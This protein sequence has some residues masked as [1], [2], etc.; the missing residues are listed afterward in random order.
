MNA[1]HLSDNIIRLRHERKLTQE[2]LADFIGV[3]KA[4]VSKWEH[5]QSMPDLLLLPQLASFFGVSI[6]EL[7]GYEAQLS[8]EQIRRYYAE[9]SKDFVQ[10]PFHEVVEKIR[11]LAH[12]YYSCYP[13]LIQLCVLYWNHFMLAETEEE[14]VQ[15]LQEAI[16]WC[17]RILDHCSNVGVCGEA[18]TVKAGISLQLGKVAEVIDILE[19]ASDPFHVAGQSEAILIQAYQMVGD[20]AK[21]K[22][23]IQ[24]KQYINLLNMVGNAVLFL[25]LYRTDLKLCEETIRRIQ[26]V[27]DLYELRA[28][29]PNLAAQF[30]FQEA[31]LYAANE[32][33]KETL[34]ALASFEKSIG[35]LL[36]S[37]QPKL[38]GDAYFD[39]LDEWIDRLPLG[40]MAP[41]DS[42]FVQQSIEE[43]FTNPAFDWIQNDEAFQRIVGRLLSERE[44]GKEYL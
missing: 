19:P 6:D 43:A 24:A 16:V 41:R 36:K 32:K 37:G 44:A 21:A 13:F 10:L 20:I 22:S 23:Y 18:L 38:H 27:M 5:A 33:K 31:V 11:F 28:L 1:L 8:E 12:Q 15:L 17:D 3:T 9:L 39:L 40:S 2:E 4:S 30:Y 14:R 7:I 35:E 34:E 29:H 26:G 42:K 25:T